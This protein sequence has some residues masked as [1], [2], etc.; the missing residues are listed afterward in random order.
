MERKELTLILEV[1]SDLK[2]MGNLLESEKSLLEG[3][4]EWICNDEELR[5]ICV[6]KLVDFLL[7]EKNL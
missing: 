6:A 5:E 1:I 3:K 2:D 7:P 4:Y